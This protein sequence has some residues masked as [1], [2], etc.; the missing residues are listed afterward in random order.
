MEAGDSTRKRKRGKR[1]CDPGRTEKKR[2]RQDRNL[3]DN[4]TLTEHLAAASNSY[5]TWTLVPPI[6][7][8]KQYSLLVEVAH[9]LE[10]HLPHLVRR[11]L[12]SKTHGG[13]HSMDQSVVITEVDTDRSLK[14]G[15]TTQRIAGVPKDTMRLWCM[16][17]PRLVLAYQQV[18]QSFVDAD[19]D[20]DD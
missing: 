20:Q 11:Q 1:S 3:I 15:I 8:Q 19:P 6:P 10:R 13:D 4:V 14:T 17:L 16:G 7:E 2:R 12:E 9:A 5:R 18:V